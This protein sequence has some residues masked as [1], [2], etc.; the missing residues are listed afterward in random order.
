MG[1]AEGKRVIVG[2]LI[3]IW[4]LGGTIVAIAMCR[5]SGRA[6]ERDRE[7]IREHFDKLGDDPRVV[8]LFRG[9]KPYHREGL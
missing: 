5:A 1:R 4:L 7:M 8:S 6:D 2:G 9:E 3:A